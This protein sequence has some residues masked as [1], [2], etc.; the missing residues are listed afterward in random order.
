MPLNPDSDE[1]PHSEYIR[2]AWELGGRE[3]ALKLAKIGL[4]SLDTLTEILAYGETDAGKRGPSYPARLVVADLETGRELWAKD[5]YIV[6][7]SPS[8]SKFVSTQPI[9]CVELQ[10]SGTVELYMDLDAGGALGKYRGRFPSPATGFPG[11]TT[12]KITWP[13]ILIGWEQ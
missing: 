8:S 5:I 9:E 7:A 2:Q 12:I 10:F 13:E 1:L 6:R 3:L 11:Q 4:I